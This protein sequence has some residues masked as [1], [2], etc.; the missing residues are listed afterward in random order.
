M[1]SFAENMMY[2][3]WGVAHILRRFKEARSPSLRNRS[4]ETKQLRLCIFLAALNSSRFLVV[5]MDHRR[6]LMEGAPK[7]ELN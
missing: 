3:I 6:W 1:Q 7:L 4:S 5:P 2:R